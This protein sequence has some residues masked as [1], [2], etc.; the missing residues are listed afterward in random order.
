MGIVESRRCCRRTL[1]QIQPPEVCFGA[2]NPPLTSNIAGNLQTVLSCLLEDP[3]PCF[4]NIKSLLATTPSTLSL[5][6]SASTSH[7][8]SAHNNNNRIRKA[9]PRGSCMNKPFSQQEGTNPRSSSISTKSNSPATLSSEPPAN[10]P[11]T[12]ANTS[13]WKASY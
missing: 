12:D 1:R 5:T 9:N 8:P 7:R 13:T 4:G 2:S 11:P 3:P 6:G 10:P